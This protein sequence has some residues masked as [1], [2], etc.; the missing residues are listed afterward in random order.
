M[1]FF[2]PKVIIPTVISLAIFFF[3]IGLSGR[4]TLFRALV[5]PPIQ[6]GELVGLVLISMIFQGATWFLFLRRLDVQATLPEIAFCFSGGA[7][8]KNLPAGVFFQNYLLNRVMGAHVS[9]TAGASI[10][11]IALEG[12]VTFFFLL[13][14][15]LPSAP[16]LRW[17]LGLIASVSILIILASWHHQLPNRLLNWGRQHHHPRIQQA[18]QEIDH[19]VSGLRILMAVH[20]LTPG[21]LLIA[22]FLAAQGL[23]LYVICTHLPIPQMGILPSM[24]VLAFSIFLPIIFPFPIQFG[25]TEVSGVAAMMAFGASQPKAIAAMLSFRLWGLGLSIILGLLG[26]LMFPEQMKKALVSSSDKD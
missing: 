13:V 3:L 7:V 26:M 8:A 22:A 21:M 20:L 12:V 19:F 2:S 4:Q 17:A 9:Y 14:L 25:F 24:D 18:A 23:T 10:S 6:I 5:L 16:W 11:L 1:R 15:G